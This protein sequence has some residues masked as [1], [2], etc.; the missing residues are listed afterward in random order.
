MNSSNRIELVLSQT[1]WSEVADVAAL[2][3]TTVAESARACVH[4]A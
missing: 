2:Q 4:R 3:G 1:E